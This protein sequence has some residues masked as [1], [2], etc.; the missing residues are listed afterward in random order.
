MLAAARLISWLA[1][2]AL[3]LAPW[4][5][6]A[7]DHRLDIRT[8]EGV[9]K[10]RFKNGNVDG[11]TYVSEDVLEVVRVAPDAAYVRAH[12]DFYNGHIC[13]ISG[14]A[15]VEAGDLVYRTPAL[16]AEGAPGECVL[17]VSPRRDAVSLADNFTCREYCGARGMFGGTRFPTASRRPIRYMPRLKASREFTDAMAKYSQAA[18]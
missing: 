18:R 15:R 10:H 14:V 9:Y 6:S 16:Q 3:L 5:G 17:R 2:C 12:L 4:P 7:A 8:I 11:E 13:A 1:L